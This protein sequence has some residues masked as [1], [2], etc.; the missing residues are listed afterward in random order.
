M[1]TILILNIV[2]SA[3]MTGLIWLIQLVHYPSFKFIDQSRFIEF[4]VFHSRMITYIVAPLMAFEVMIAGLLVAKLFSPLTLLCFALVL[5]NWV[6]TAFL[7][8]PCHQAL[9]QN[10]D[11]NTIDRLIKTNWIRTWAW[12]LKTFFSLLILQ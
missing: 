1:N 9:T 10:Y 3:M 7:S 5:L 6:V 11:E 12:T 4:E 8:V 2:F